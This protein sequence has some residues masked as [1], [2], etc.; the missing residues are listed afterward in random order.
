MAV[1][2][3]GS[4]VAGGAAQGAQ[5]GSIAGP[6]GMV[7]GAAFGAL[8]GALNARKAR[9]QRRRM[10]RK[11][12]AARAAAD[13]T[14]T[15][16]TAEGSTFARARDFLKSSFGE[17]AANTGFA[18]N[19]AQGVRSA[20]AGRG[21]FTGNIGAL[22]E[23]QARSFAAQ[24]LQGQLAPLAQSFEFAPEILRQQL[25]Q[26]RFNQDLAIQDNSQS[27]FGAIAGGILQGGVGGA[28]LGTSI[29]QQFGASGQ[30]PQDASGLAGA[31]QLAGVQAID[32][33]QQNV[34][35]IDQFLTTG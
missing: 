25:T 3:G 12:A 16:L 15:R 4:S 20:Q 14:V 11:L 31:N 21:L 9:K 13:E 28:Q 22:Q 18:Q 8:S 27:S 1:T 24:K 35:N 34:S 17:N 19:V 32:E 2:S 6:M 29:A 7:V 10:R 5:A 26:G 33:G 30:G 23:G